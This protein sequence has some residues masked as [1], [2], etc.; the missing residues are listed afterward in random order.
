LALGSTNTEDDTGTERCS[1]PLLND[2]LYFQKHW[3]AERRDPLSRVEM[4][5]HGECWLQC[6]ERD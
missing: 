5:E 2:I 6:C 3:D 4:Q 1:I